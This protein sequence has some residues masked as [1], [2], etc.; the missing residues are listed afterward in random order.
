MADEYIKI[1]QL[2]GPRTAFEGADRHRLVLS[3]R[4]ATSLKSPC[5]QVDAALAQLTEEN[6]PRLEIRARADEGGRRRPNEALTPGSQRDPRATNEINRN[7]ARTRPEDALR[8]DRAVGARPLRRRARQKLIPHSMITP[9]WPCLPLFD[10]ILQ[11]VWKTEKAKHP[12]PKESAEKLWKSTHG[13]KSDGFR[14]I[15][16]RR[17]CQIDAEVHRQAG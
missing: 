16:R 14:Q 10:E 12:A 11:Q 2:W 17:L 4:A 8:S 15:S 3:S 13:G 7:P 6:D 5:N 9:S 1:A